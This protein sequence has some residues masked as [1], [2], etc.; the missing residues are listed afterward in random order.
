MQ[1]VAHF[2]CCNQNKSWRERENKGII[3]NRK[4]L[5]KWTFFRKEVGGKRI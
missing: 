3:R 4:E 2:Q 5:G 1:I